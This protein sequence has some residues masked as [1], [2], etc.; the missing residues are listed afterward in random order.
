VKIV[1]SGV[2]RYDAVA[3]QPVDIVAL[4]YDWWYELAVAD[5]SVD[6]GESATPVGD[7]G[8]LYYV[9]FRRAGSR[10]RPTWVDSIGHRTLD[11]AMADAESRVP[12]PITW[13]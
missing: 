4:H 12:S 2:W 8:V 11:A 3:T 9:R 13:T 5:G 7:D 6:P 10:A 1:K